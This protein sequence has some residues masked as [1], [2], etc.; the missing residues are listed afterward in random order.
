M[1]SCM[2]QIN[3]LELI[4]KYLEKYKLP[5]M[6]EE[7]IENL[8]NRD[9]INNNNNNRNIPPKSPGPDLLVNF[10]KLLKM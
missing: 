10:I 5:K 6:T 4:N 7:E 3:N 8:N 2:S 9:K 1:N